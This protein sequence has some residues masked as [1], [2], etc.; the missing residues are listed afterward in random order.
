MESISCWRSSGRNGKEKKK[1]RRK[2][3]ETRQKNNF[4]VDVG[5]IRTDAPEG[6]RFL[7]LRIRPLCHHALRFR[8]IEK[9]QKD[10][11]ASG[12]GHWRCQVI[13]LS[14]AIFPL[15]CNSHFAAA[16]ENTKWKELI[17]AATLQ[18]RQVRRNLETA[19]SAKIKAVQPS[20]AGHQEAASGRT[21][22]Q[23]LIMP[24]R[25]GPGAPRI[26]VPL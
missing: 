7:V 20:P 15:L 6:T 3:K 2:E 21:S 16:F 23:P 22:P 11:E 9:G 4:V 5:L 19:S 25:S 26:Y 24:R 10:T 18:L 8:H 17:V 12:K 14:R 13:F 1:N